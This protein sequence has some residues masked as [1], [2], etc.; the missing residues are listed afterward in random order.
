MLRFTAV[1]ACTCRRYRCGGVH[2]L[3]TALVCNWNTNK[4]RLLFDSYEL[5]NAVLLRVCQ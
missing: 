1:S 4:L 2:H 3:M 5:F